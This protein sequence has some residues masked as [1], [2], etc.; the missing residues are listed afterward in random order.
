MLNFS[1]QGGGRTHTSPRYKLGAVTNLATWVY[2][3][4]G[5]NR[6]NWKTY[7]NLD[8]L[9]RPLFSRNYYLNQSLSQLATLILISSSSKINHVHPCTLRR[10]FK[11]LLLCNRIRTYI[12]RLNAQCPPVRRYTK[13]NSTSTAISVF[14]DLINV[15]FVGRRKIT[16]PEILFSSFIPLIWYNIIF[17][18]LFFDFICFRVMNPHSTELTILFTFLFSHNLRY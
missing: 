14:L 3:S 10:I 16:L 9:S 13:T 18:F 12:P 1:T 2:W 7:R 6:T 4:V 11:E 8:I 15:F 17:Y 5:R